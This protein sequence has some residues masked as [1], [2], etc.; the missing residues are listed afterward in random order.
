M[1]VISQCLDPFPPPPDLAGWA[2]RAQIPS[3]LLDIPRGTPPSPPP[4]ICS[5]AWL[6]HTLLG[7]AF[8]LFWKGGSELWIESDVDKE[9]WRWI[10]NRLSV[11]FLF[12]RTGSRDR[13][14]YL[15][16]FKV[17]GLK[18]SLLIFDWMILWWAI[19]FAIFLAVKGKIY[20]RI[21]WGSSPSTPQYYW[22]CSQLHSN[23]FLWTGN[24][25]GSCKNSSFLCGPPIGFY[26]ARNH[27][28]AG[29]I[30]Q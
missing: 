15:E 13:I 2:K 28:W 20:Y 22:K 29:T 7:R 3:L 25:R 18:E 11:Y 27:I 14:K 9:N 4:P 12:L 19:V 8:L 16:K 5:Q 24:V 17:L 23:G 26:Q 30:D 10:Q 6:A 1:P 21:P